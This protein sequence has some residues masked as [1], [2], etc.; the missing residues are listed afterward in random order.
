MSELT[1][2][3]LQLAFLALLWIFVFVIVYAMRSDLFGARVRRMKEAPA[4]AAPAPTPVTTPPS[5]APAPKVPT[6]V[7]APGTE[8]SGPPRATTS[9]AGRLVITSGPKSGAEIPLGTEPLT[10]GRSSDSSVVIR[11]DYTSTHHAR[12]MVW[13]EEWVVQDLDSTNGTF[14]DGQRVT[15]PLHVTLNTPIRIGATTFELRR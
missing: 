10:I 11:D 6:F 3:I 13:G 9:N 7:P 15:S 2:L 4:A 5:G 14:L 1:L 8:L 12:L